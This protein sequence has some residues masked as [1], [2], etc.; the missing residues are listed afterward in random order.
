[1]SDIVQKKR[2]NFW[3]TLKAITKLQNKNKQNTTKG[4]LTL[5]KETIRMVLLILQ[6]RVMMFIILLEHNHILIKDFLN[7][8][9]F[10]LLKQT[11]LL[12]QNR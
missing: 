2:T 12:T 3:I 6:S 5:N 9:S 7:K 8:K 4:C 10:R 11:L 1:M